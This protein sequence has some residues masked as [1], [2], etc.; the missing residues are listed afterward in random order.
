[1]N[2]RVDELNGSESR[3]VAV[4][5]LV[6]LQGG[7][8]FS[9]GLR[10]CGS[11]EE[12]ED[13]VQETFLQ[14]YEHWSQFEGRSSATTWLY[15]IAA[16][17][18]QRFHRRKVGEPDQLESLEELL[19]LG[20]PSMGVVP[21]ECDSPLGEGI[22]A[23]G[24]A[25]IEEAIAAL[26]LEFRMPL[27]LKEIV[28]LSLAE[29]AGIMDMKE[30]TVKTR[31]HRARLRIRKALDS[32]LPS[33]EVPPPIYSKQICLDLL[34]AKQECLDR[35]VDFE[36]PDNI[37]CERCSELFSTMD[38]AQSICT[39]IAQGAMP[40]ELRRQLMEKMGLEDSQ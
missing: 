27:V 33:R 39:D 12:A 18:C 40:G 1:M 21:A 9:L 24:R 3:E 11:R 19:P 30:A 16:R 10:F 5:R 31:L 7:R 28:G 22:R 29:I 37:V 20:E 8:L 34:Q 23:E 13:L 14:A 35:G 36:F 15:T 38:F 6:E 25:Q 2:E 32:A 26:P 4:T 17:V